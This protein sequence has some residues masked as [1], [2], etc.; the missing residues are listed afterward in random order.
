MAERKLLPCPFCGSPGEI[1]TGRSY[2]DR[3]HEFASQ[4]EAMRWLEENVQPN[5]TKF[6]VHP[7]TGRKAGKSG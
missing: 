3:A 4:A 1:H 2:E 6:G 7:A 5:S